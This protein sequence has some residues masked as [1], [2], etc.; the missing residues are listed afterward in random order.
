MLLVDD[1]EIW[2]I[3]ELLN[4]RPV[5]QVN[6]VVHSCA[7]VLIQAPI[8][9]AREVL[10]RPVLEF[11]SGPETVELLDHGQVAHVGEVV[12]LHDGEQG[13]R[14]GHYRSFYRSPVHWRGKME[15]APDA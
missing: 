9:A 8:I 3:A 12:E 15:S 6:V 4:A 1:F 13:V 7:R 14:S 10:A 2:S 5:A 11:R